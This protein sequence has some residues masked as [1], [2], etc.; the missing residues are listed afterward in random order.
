M[1]AVLATTYK[2]VFDASQKGPDWWFPAFGL[3]FVAM[4]VGLLLFRRRLPAPWAQ[5]PRYTKAF[6]SVCLGFSVLWTLISGVGI[7]GSWWSAR[8]ALASGTAQVVEGPVEQFSAMPYTGHGSDHFVVNGVYFS[9]SD[10]EVTPGFNRTASHG[11]AVHGGEF[12]RIHYINQRGGNVIL[13]LAIREG[14]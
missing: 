10:Y 11:G 6:A 4:G 3:I 13:K 8:E 7:F 1:A 14:S 5:K 12:V 9:Y 2:V